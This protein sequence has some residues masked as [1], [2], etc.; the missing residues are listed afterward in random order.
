MHIFVMNCLA[1]IDGLP[2]VANEEKAQEII[3]MDKSMIE[4]RPG[5]I[6]WEKQELKW[7]DKMGG[8]NKTGLYQRMKLLKMG[9]R[10]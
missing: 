9:H 7:F 6:E 5:F 3:E 10:K 8:N 1:R 2:D 4:N